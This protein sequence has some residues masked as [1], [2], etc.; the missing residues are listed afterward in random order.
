[1]ILGGELDKLRDE[2]S[3]YYNKMTKIAAHTF[4]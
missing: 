3:Q 4:L 1:M 2:L